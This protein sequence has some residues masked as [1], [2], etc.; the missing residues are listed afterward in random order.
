MTK[1]VVMMEILHIRRSKVVIKVNTII[2]LHL[3]TQKVL[4]FFRL[5]LDPSN[6]YLVHDLDSL[7]LLIKDIK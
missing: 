6:F 7:S 3:K 2:Q 5:E 4:I 1:Q